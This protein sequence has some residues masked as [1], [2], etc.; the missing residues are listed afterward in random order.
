MPNFSEPG[1]GI[2]LDLAGA[3]LQITG[4][5]LMANYYLGAAHRRQ[6]L[7][8]LVSALFRG[9]HARGA[10]AARDLNDD[11][12]VLVLQ[13]LALMALGFLLQALALLVPLFR[14]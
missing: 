11:D 4:A 3:F 5:V 1:V 14:G 8:V 7:W 2:W 12:G 10:A 13:G 9:T 6:W